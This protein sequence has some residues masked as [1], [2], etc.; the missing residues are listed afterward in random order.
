MRDFTE[1]IG[2]SQLKSSGHLWSDLVSVGLP[3]F[4]RREQFGSDTVTS[5]KTESSTRPQQQPQ[6]SHKLAMQLITKAASL[7]VATQSHLHTRRNI[8]CR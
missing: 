6:A 7:P 1:Y 4:L 5:H 3:M 8:E 2:N